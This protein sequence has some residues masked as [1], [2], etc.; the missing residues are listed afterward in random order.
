V[1]SLIW[2]FFLRPDFLSTSYWNVQLREGILRTSGTGKDKYSGVKNWGSNQRIS[3]QNPHRLSNWE[4]GKYDLQMITFRRFRNPT[5]IV[6]IETQGAEKTSSKLTLLNGVNKRIINIQSPEEETTDFSS[7]VNLGFDSDML[8]FYMEGNKRGR[9]KRG[10]QVLELLISQSIASKNVFKSASFFKAEIG[11]LGYSLMASSGI[12][13][14]GILLMRCNS[15]RHFALSPMNECFFISWKCT[16]TLP[17]VTTEKIR[18]FKPFITGPN[19]P[20]ILGLFPHDESIIPVPS[21]ISR[22]ITTRLL[23]QEASERTLRERCRLFRRRQR[24]VRWGRNKSFF[25]SSLILLS[26]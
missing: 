17:L 15:S 11:K 2:F 22:S 24:V 23:F 19:E 4:S 14:P 3:C 16:W 18:F 5:F 8:P 21:E 1:D 6:A 10:T 7:T 12:W 13:T 25:R 26:T 9:Q 20:V